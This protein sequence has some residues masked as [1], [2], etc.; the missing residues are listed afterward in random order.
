[1]KDLS[2]ADVQRLAKALCEETELIN[3]GRDYLDAICSRTDRASLTPENLMAIGRDA[4][5]PARLGR[6]VVL[7][8]AQV[9]RRHTGLHNYAGPDGLKWQMSR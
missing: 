8:W 1:M 2:P 6:P 5:D 3:R 9:Y 4:D 7:S